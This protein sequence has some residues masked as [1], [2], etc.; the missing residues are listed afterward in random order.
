MNIQ[1]LD[2]RFK[3]LEIKKI[4]PENA[5]TSTFVFE[6]PLNSKPGQFV[7]LWIPGV[8]EKPFSVAY[9]DG[10]E[11]WLTI[12]KVGQATEELFKLK[13]GDKVGIRGPLG[14]HYTWSETDHIGVVAGGYGAAPMYFVSRLAIKDGCKVE[15]FV[16]A[17]SEDLLLF[18]EKAA[19]LDN[20]TVHIATNDGSK[21]HKGFVT[22]AL[23]QFLTNQK[24]DRVFSCGPELMMQAA[25][26]VAEKHDVKSWLSME[27]YMKCGIG[28]CGQCAVD[29][30]GVLV[31]T[32][33]PVMSY[34]EVKT[35][36][37]LGKY[38][39]DAQGV[40]HYF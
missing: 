30:S 26:K 28:V 19:S 36:P 14:T 11:F 18:T 37:E 3:A 39:R 40:K 5:Y 4:I 21:G 24:L 31:C 33:G 6:Y 34:D 22:E 10:K 8:D 9:D 38:H 13:V 25:S 17:R 2:S 35:L 29:D 27:K 20:V 1:N 32:K 23:D 12:C 15:F 16:G 7:M